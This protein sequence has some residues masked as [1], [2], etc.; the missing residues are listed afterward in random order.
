MKNVK[1]VGKEV[2]IESL[3]KNF[4]NACYVLCRKRVTWESKFSKL[5]RL[6]CIPSEWGFG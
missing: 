1:L 6:A 4:L 3:C 5:T 2:Q